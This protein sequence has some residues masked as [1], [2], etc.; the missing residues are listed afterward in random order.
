MLM[1]SQTINVSQLRDNLAAYLSA[2]ERG[3]E[4]MVTNHGRVVAKLSPV[5]QPRRKLGLLKGKIG[6]QPDDAW[7]FPGDLTDIMEG[8]VEG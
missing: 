7:E 5:E 8:K 1:A 3:Q 4:V 2:A 6:P